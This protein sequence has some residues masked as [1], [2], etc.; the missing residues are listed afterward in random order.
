M[1]TAFSLLLAFALATPV[2]AQEPVEPG[3]DDLFVDRV[4][5]VVGDTAIFNSDL[6]EELNRL[7]AQGIAAPEAP[8]ERLAYEREVLDR[9]V[10]ENLI[11]RAAERDS[12]ITIPEDRVDAEL[13]V[14]WEQEVQSFGSEGALETA[15]ATAGRTLAQ[16]RASRREEIR[17]GLLQQAYVQRQQQQIRIPPI[18]EAEIRAF[19]ESEQALFGPRP[20]A[21]SF[22]QVV[23]VPEPSDSA[24]AAAVAEAER[25]LG[26][27]DEGEDFGD[28]A[29][30]LSDDPGS[31]QM[32]GEVGWVRQGTRVLEF[33]EAVFRLNRGQ[34]S[35]VVETPFGA[36]I[37][38]L[39]RIRG[40]ERLVS[41]IAFA[42]TVT[43]ADEAA[44]RAR[45]A[46]IRDAVAA[47]ASIADFPSQGA[48]I[49]IPDQLEVALD[50]LNQLPAGYA[51]S[52]RTAEE[53]QVLDP[54]DFVWQG[55][56]AV[57]V[58][59]VTAV[60]D[61]GAYTYEE[62]RDQLRE[63]IARSRFEDRLIDRLR[64]QEYVDIRY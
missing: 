52:L 34:I 22:R 29:R 20:A 14:A 8:D 54:I 40:A 11:V 16:H 28:L 32:G 44:V 53:G 25:V 42:A 17:K 19:F 46:E 37:I 5:A 4:V 58:V 45:A 24:R 50:Q 36:H 43:D 7:E 61:A 9:L 31:A 1:R 18:E 30:R 51:F 3:P 63:Q 35:D 39:D 62:V 27:L 21:V 23:L 55:Q 48:T 26:L 15:L 38:R 64:A 33:E 10:I 59:H 47:G 56:T 6:R 60:R 12:L 57:A 2:A 41:H 49:G 13:E